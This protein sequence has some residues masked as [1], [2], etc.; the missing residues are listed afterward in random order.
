M[1]NQSYFSGISISGSSTL[2]PCYIKNGEN[3]LSFRI[4]GW[5]KG[6]ILSEHDPLTLAQMDVLTLDYLNW[7][8]IQ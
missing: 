8:V 7:E 5:L 2:F 6:R 4:F 3:L 1:P